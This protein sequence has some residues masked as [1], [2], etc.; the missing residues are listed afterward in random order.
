MKPTFCKYDNLST[1]GTISGRRRLLSF[2]I[3]TDKA[4]TVSGVYL[5]LQ[6][7]DSSGDVLLK[8]E[9]CIAAGQTAIYAAY[10]AI[11]ADM[12][13]HGILFPDGIYV[14]LTDLETI[15]DSNWNIG[16]YSQG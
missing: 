13:S 15:A 16:I 4:A 2:Q 3:L 11:T 9:F 12:T 10:E 1:S 6:N 5:I 14:D 8:W 7:G